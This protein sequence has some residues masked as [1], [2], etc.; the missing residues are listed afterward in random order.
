MGMYE[1]V[2]ISALF[3]AYIILIY[4]LYNYYNINS[5]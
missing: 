3:G 1:N 4:V 5:K 2:N